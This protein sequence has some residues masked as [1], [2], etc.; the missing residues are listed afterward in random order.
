MKRYAEH[1]FCNV[2]LPGG[3]KP[4]WFNVPRKGDYFL[5]GVNHVVKCNG[6]MKRAYLI[7]DRTFEHGN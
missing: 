6:K 4:R 3:W 7:V 1:I 2:E 5:Y